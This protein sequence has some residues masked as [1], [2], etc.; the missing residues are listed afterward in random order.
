MNSP[1]IPN[2][3]GPHPV[4]IT[5][6]AAHRYNRPYASFKQPLVI[7]VEPEGLMPWGH[8]TALLFLRSKP[9]PGNEGDCAALLVKGLS[10]KSKMSIV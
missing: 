1:F 8:E 10:G 6:H 5:A 7:F 9:L 2:A 3:P 4:G